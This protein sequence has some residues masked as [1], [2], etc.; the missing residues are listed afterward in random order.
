MSS[1]QTALKEIPPNEAD[2]DAD[3]ATASTGAKLNAVDE[4][5]AAADAT[6]DGVPRQLRAEIKT[7]PIDPRDIRPSWPLAIASLERLSDW[8]VFA[9]RGSAR[10]RSSRSACASWQEKT[11]GQTPSSACAR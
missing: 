10:S 4:P 6:A 2:A 1:S 5:S 11:L 3:S 8:C 9:L 7:A